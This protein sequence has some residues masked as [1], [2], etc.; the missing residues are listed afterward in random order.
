MNISKL[1]DGFQ[2]HNNLFITDKIGKILF[3]KS[4][5]IVLNTQWNFPFIRNASRFEFQF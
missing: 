3:F 1:R 4:D 5:S 2:F